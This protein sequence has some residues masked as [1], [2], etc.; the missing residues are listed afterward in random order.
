M[1]ELSLVVGCALF[2]YGMGL[3]AGAMIWGPL[4]RYRKDVR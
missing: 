4:R 3:L 2:G 1:L